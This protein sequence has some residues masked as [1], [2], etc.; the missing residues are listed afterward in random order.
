MSARSLLVGALLL[1]SQNCS[2][3][4]ITDRL[5]AGF[6]LS[7]DLTTDP[8]RALPNGT[9]MEVLAERGNFAQVRLGDNSEG[10][11][12]T[13]YITQETPTKTLLLELQAKYAR[14][15]R[16]VDSAKEAT[17][18]DPS[19]TLSI[20]SEMPTSDSSVEAQ[21]RI[22]ELE[23]LVAKLQQGT[24]GSDEPSEAPQHNALSSAHLVQ[25]S[26]HLPSE[27]EKPAVEPDRGSTPIWLFP[28]LLFGMLLGFVAG[29]AY[30]NYRIA[31]RIGLSSPEDHDSDL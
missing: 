19:Q 5:L 17:G 13:R 10:W 26:T 16:Q 7:P 9:P 30:K 14:L 20:P 18:S 12:E 24:D 23:N 28:L 22:R 4:Y 27:P 3:A 21:Q 29:I 6:Y 25:A 31:R 15:K 11:V 2:S 8:V 1:V